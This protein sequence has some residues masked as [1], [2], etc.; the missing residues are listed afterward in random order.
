MR[1]KTVKKNDYPVLLLFCV[2]VCVSVCAQ[3]KTR[4]EEDSKFSLQLQ[5]R[6][7][8]WDSV[9]TDLP[10]TTQ[11]KRKTKKKTGKKSVKLL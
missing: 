3:L 2:C 5:M 8:E 11:K 4:K 1:Q 6:S 10:A 7:T 9:F